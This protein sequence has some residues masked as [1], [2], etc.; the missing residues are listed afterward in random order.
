[1]KKILL[2][3]IALLIIYIGNSY[4]QTWEEVPSS[5]NFILYGMSFPP[6][7]NDVGY[8]CGMQYTFDAPGVIIK[9]T[10]G[11][12]TWSTIL[13]VSGEID[14]LQ[15]I[16]FIDENIGFAG[17]WND[18]FIKTTDGGT[19]WTDLTVGSDN[20]YFTNIVF[21][22]DNNGVATAD[23]NSGGSAIYVTD[24][25][26]DTWTT[27]TGVTQGILGITYATAS[28]LFAVGNGSQVLK[29]TNGGNS[30]SSIYTTSGILFSVDFYSANFGVVGGEDGKMLATT[31]GGG[32]WSSYSTG[33]ENLWA[34]K[35]FAGDSAYIGGTDENIY[36]TIDGG[37]NWTIEYNGP[38]SSNL[39][40][41]ISTE[42]NTLLS[43]GSQ[44]KMLL[45]SAPLNADFSADQTTICE[46]SS[47]NFID[48]SA[49]AVS[50]SWTFEGGNPA[51]STDQNPTVTY[52]TAGV[53]DV[54]LTVTDGLGGSSTLNKP[55]YILVIVAPGQADAPTG[56]DEL[57][58]G[59]TYE[60]TTNPVVYAENY[61]WEVT[62]ASA[63]TIIGNGT[64]VDFEVSE[65]FSG[66]FTIKVRAWNICDY[67]A[68]SDD[69]TG[70]VNPSPA[71]FELSGSGEIC[72][73][74]PGVEITLSGSEADVDYELFNNQGSTG[75]IVAGTG[76][77]ISFGLFAEQNNYTAVGFTATCSTEMIGEGSVLVNQLPEQL[78]TPEG[79]SEVC[80][81]DENQYTTTNAQNS[82][83]V[84]WT[85]TP[86]NAGTIESNGMTATIMWNNTFE[87]T[88]SLTV[89]AEN[90]CG[91]GP[92]SGALEIAVFASPSPEI[93]GDILVCNEEV[94]IYS[95]NG[96]DGN[97][98]DWEVF[99]GEIISGE[100]SPQIT[101]SWGNAPGQGYVIL[102]ESL[103]LGCSAVDTLDVTIDDC[104]GIE[105]NLPN[106]NIKIYPNP[107][108]EFVFIQSN[109]K[110]VQVELIDD[111]SRSLSNYLVQ[112]TQINIKL[113]NVQPGFYL[114]KITT[115]KETLVR[116]LIIKK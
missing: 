91:A 89:Y 4:S 52:S 59:L 1:M 111:A 24:D 100:G 25:G 22:D 94:S 92:L 87:G 36:K 88:A 29:S 58:S 63:G 55:N 34:A 26:G 5:T 54:S 10:D 113:N 81:N 15:A 86:E 14:G 64:S 104:T 78:S 2:T 102:N 38:G 28:T 6:G 98:Y 50:W 73:G 101:V 103:E 115:E 33:Y 8:A 20:W 32:S 74:D 12:E 110:I 21:W 108:S 45:K 105:S 47:V 90:S 84:I 11:G 82:D 49:A 67:G 68:W 53:Y 77:P 61:D 16:C 75:I 7:Q 17:G 35:A 79:T 42:N 112:D 66:S 44:G 46:G 114:V 71:E 80:N 107:A 31:N 37:Q 9:T 72:E 69:F 19:S 57:C 83:Q 95:T 116:K 30:W 23:L 51:T 43:C 76:E 109:E 41:I 85:L 27:A 40:K 3:L 62:P 13:P 39:Y 96:N 60:Y 48:E 18:Y 56:S 93:A 65:S 106:N 97:N 70:T 99:G